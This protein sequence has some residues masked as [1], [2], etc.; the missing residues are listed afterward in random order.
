M[1]FGGLMFLFTACETKIDDPAGARDEA[2]VPG[3]KNLNPATYDVN[4]LENTY[5]Q[6]DLSAS[7]VDQAA[8]LVSFGKGKERKEVAR[9]STFPANITIPLTDVVNA[10][11]MN[12]DDV[13][14]ADVFTFEVQTFQGG[15]SYFSS[16]AFKVAV[17]CGYETENVT[18][19]YTAYSSPDEWDMEGSV[20]LVADEDDQYIVYI[21][22][23]A[24]AEGLEEIAPIKM[25]INPLDFSVTVPK[26]TIADNAFGYTGYSYAGSGSLNTCNGTYEL[27]M[28]VTVDQGSFG[29]FEYTFTKK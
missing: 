23:Y 14:A 7:G 16:A 18:G 4:D 12:L 19:A 26:V 21:H 13:E 6:F 15:K 29:S 10:L 8:V 11:G 24:T 17:V 22:G 2:A 3:V 28:S 9:V 20:N 1:I 5:I 27:M 25:I